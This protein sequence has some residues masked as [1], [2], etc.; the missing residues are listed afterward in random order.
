MKR[1]ELH[2]A[3]YPPTVY[4][5][6]KVGVR[7]LRDAYGHLVRELGVGAVLLLDGGTDILLRGDE[8]GLG[9][10]EEDILSLAA[11]ARLAGVEALGVTQ[12]KVS[13]AASRQAG[14]LLRRTLD[15]P[16]DATRP[17]RRNRYPPEASIAKNG[18]YQRGGG[19]RVGHWPSDI[20]L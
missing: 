4:A 18:L 11:V 9:T 6:E 14:G 12:P 1:L 16:I 15:E 8:A 10:P 20:I 19:M 17:G 3:G 2:E 5:F 7:P 13:G